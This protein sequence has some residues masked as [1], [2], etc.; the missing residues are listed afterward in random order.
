MITLIIIAV[1]VFIMYKLHTRLMDVDVEY[2]EDIVG[3]TDKVAD[4][5]LERVV[6]VLKRIGDK[7]S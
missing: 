7:L 4:E 6:A 3:D 2:R 1:L 5:F